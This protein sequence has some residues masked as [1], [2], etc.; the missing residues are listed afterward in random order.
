[1]ERENIIHAEIQSI[2]WKK[3]NKREI[4]EGSLR[5][6]YLTAMIDQGEKRWVL[7]NV[8]FV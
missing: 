1:L 3:K 8:G 4:R 2:P 5:A 7:K 6:P